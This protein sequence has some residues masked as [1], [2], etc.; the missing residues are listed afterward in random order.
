MTDKYFAGGF[1]FH[2]QSGKVL[3]QWRGT[4]T[5]SNPNTWC[6]LGGWSEEGDR[7]N[8]RVTWCR[9]MH[10]EIGVVIDPKHIVLLCDYLPT[11]NPYHRYI[12]YREWP[13]VAEDFP[14][15]EDEE[16]LAAVKWFT[17]EEAL[18]LPDLLTNGTRRDLTLFQERLRAV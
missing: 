17:V 11:S 14:L 2:P 12:F 10:E 18:A 1:L 9:E 5:S 4:K 6:F 16:D 3:L 15:P 8:P 7:G 13:T